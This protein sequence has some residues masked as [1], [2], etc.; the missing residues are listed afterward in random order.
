MP[1]RWQLTHGPS[2]TRDV[3][4][5]V[6][7]NTT[8]VKINAEEGSVAISAIV[9]DDPSGVLDIG[10]MHGFN[11]TETD[12]ASA[13]DNSFY[14]GFVADRGIDR[15]AADK[16]FRTGAARQWAVNS[17]DHN[18]RLSRR[19]LLGAD[20]NRPAETDVARV[21]YL[22]ASPEMST[23]GI[24]ESGYINTGSSVAMDAADYRGQTV[25]DVLNDCGLA[26]GKNYFVMYRQDIGANTFG[27][28]Y[29][30]DSSTAYTSAL[31]I[32]NVA[33]DVN[34]STVFAAAFDTKLTRDPSR[35]YSGIYLPFDSGAVY[36]QQESTASNFVRRDTTAY[37]ANVK[38]VA[39]ANARAIR[40]LADIDTEEDRITTAIIV[41]NASVNALKE[42]Q[43]IQCK[44]S[45][46]PGYEAYRYLRVLARTITQV[47]EEYY[48]LELELA[49]GDD[50]P[51]SCALILA[52][53][54]Y[55]ASATRT[56]VPYAYTPTN[57]P[58][59]PSVTLATWVGINTFDQMTVPLF[60]ASSLAA[61]YTA[62]TN[63]FS[64]YHVVITPGYRAITSGSPGSFAP[65]YAAGAAALKHVTSWVNIPT[66]ATSPV[67]TALQDT[68]GSG[69]VFG[70]FPTSG[71]LLVAQYVEEQTEP[72]SQPT[73]NAGWSALGSTVLNDGGVTSYVVTYFVKCCGA[74]E[75]KTQTPFVEPGKS[76]WTAVTEWA[77]T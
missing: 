46:L 34:G 75:S 49:P 52:G 56:T 64:E 29:D 36:Q 63:D 2:N 51:T 59:Y 37:S 77:L 53:M 71:N 62:L 45:H 72:S 26:S 8:S 28:W 15:G 32:S 67:Q 35:V 74:G 40:M 41:P 73:P 19:V 43:R 55:I 1:L 24:T 31:F 42:G 58:S 3:S 11:A 44:F 25:F 48:K 61:P 66:A 60:T 57:P 14:R 12:V 17:A 16:S 30:F 50:T 22:M 7:A 5:N 68:T 65:T 47:S 13:T 76:H 38:T 20:A 10:G 54:S 39:K 33:A 69:V 18:E 21:Q 9:V 27:L 70:S 6:R 23:V 4:G